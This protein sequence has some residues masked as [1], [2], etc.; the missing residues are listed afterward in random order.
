MRFEA[1]AWSPFLGNFSLIEGQRDFLGHIVYSMFF[2]KS[3]Y[4]SMSL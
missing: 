4:L 1:T 2:L 3:L